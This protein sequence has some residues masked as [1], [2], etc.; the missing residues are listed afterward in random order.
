M[1]EHYP[2]SHFLNLRYVPLNQQTVLLGFNGWYDYGFS[3]L[4][5][6]QQKFVRSRIF[7]G[8]IELLNAFLMIRRRIKLS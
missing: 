5:D 2:D 8:L 3:E 6:P 7:I 4:S 1:I